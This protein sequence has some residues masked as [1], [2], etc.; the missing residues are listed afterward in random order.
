ML[1]ELLRDGPA[2][3]VHLL[4]WWRQIRP[5]A[6]RLGAAIGA[7]ELAGLVTL[8]VPELQLTA[9]VRRPVQW[10]ARPDRAYLH[11]LHRGTATVLVPY[12]AGEVG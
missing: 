7:G 10:R 11:D 6:L 8:D 3:G 12:A 9:L 2:K 5:L 4:C 1:R